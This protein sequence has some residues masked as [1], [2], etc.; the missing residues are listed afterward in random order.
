[1][2]Q[3]PNNR[4]AD[5][6]SDDN[7]MMEDSGTFGGGV[8]ASV[9]TLG[10]D[11]TTEPASESDLAIAGEQ[12]Q[13]DTQANMTVDFGFYHMEIGDLV[14]G[15]VDNSGLLDGTEAGIPGVT[16]ELWTAV[17]NRRQL[18]VNYHHRCIGS[19][20]FYEYGRRRLCP[21]YSGF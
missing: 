11:I 8:T 2:R 5:I 14:W 3:S 21:S 20:W 17:L 12:G 19:V 9:V 18:P 6:D 4:N 15:D 16:V 7:G 10:P 1:M 13:P